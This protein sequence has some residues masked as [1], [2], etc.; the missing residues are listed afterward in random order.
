MAAR[1]RDT[2]ATATEWFHNIFEA[3]AMRRS[4]DSNRRAADASTRN[5]RSF[6]RPMRVTAPPML[7]IV[8]RPA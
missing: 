4:L 6:C 3:S 2:T 1:S 8:S 7:T 5:A